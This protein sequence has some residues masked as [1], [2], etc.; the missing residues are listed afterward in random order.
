MSQDSIQFGFFSS[1]ES[2]FLFID[3][4]ITSGL[5]FN[6]NEWRKNRIAALKNQSERSD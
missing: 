3:I 4:W 6:T 2:H 1:S 5:K